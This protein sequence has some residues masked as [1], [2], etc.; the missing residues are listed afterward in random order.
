MFAFFL[1]SSTTKS[2]FLRAS[3][4]AV[5][6][7]HVLICRMIQPSQNQICPATE[8]EE[9]DYLKSITYG[10]GTY[11]NFL[12]IDLIKELPKDIGYL[13]VHGFQAVDE[14]DS[15]YAKFPNA[16]K[17]TRAAFDKALEEISAKK[18]K[19]VILDLR[20]NG[21]GSPYAVQL[22]SSYFLPEDIPLNNI[23]W[24]KSD[25]I[26]IEEKN[27]LPYEQILKE[28]RLMDIPLY[29]LISHRTFSA[30]EKFANNMKAL[31]RATLIGEITMGGANPGRSHQLNDLFEIFI[32]DGQSINA[33]NGSNWEGIG[34]IPDLMVSANEALD[35][36][37]SLAKSA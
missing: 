30:G 34:V 2:F 27:T 12:R 19:S 18:P 4:R 20:N 22:L 6:Q 13:E 5:T 9:I 31:N 32:P 35:L 21:G 16:V 36:S 26:S 23:R 37:L 3:H 15:E 29:I 25:G 11:D 24:R 8:D 1:S 14:K 33:I 28:K 7:N 17:Q 10:I